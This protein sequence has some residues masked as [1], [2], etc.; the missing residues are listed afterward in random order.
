MLLAESTSQFLPPLA[1]GTLLGALVAALLAVLAGRWLLGP[2]NEVARRWSLWLVRGAIL[3]LVVLVLFNPVHVEELPGPVQRPELFY[4]LDTSSSM[5]MGSPRSRW[6]E[7]LALLR[8]AEQL[9]PK[10]PADVKAFRF[11]QRLAAVDPA[12]Q[13]GLSKLL[14]DNKLKITPASLLPADK[15]GGSKL[16]T[17][18]DADTRLLAALRQISSRFGRVPP[19]GIV[20]FSDGR[21]HDEAGLEQIAAEFARLKV[22]LHVAPVGDMSKGGDVAVSAVV[23]PPRARKFTEVDVQVFVRSFGYD[24]KRS[25]VQLLELLADGTTGRK[26][27]P[28]LPITL[29]SGFQSVSLSFRTD[30]NTRKLRVAIPPLADEVSAANNQIDAE[31][32]IER[33]KIRVLF[34][35]G[36]SQPLTQ[37]RVGDRYQIR[38]AFSDLKSALTED[39]DIECVVLIVQPGVGLA[40]VAE[41]ASVDGVRGFPTTVAELSAF[42]AII[43]SNVAAEQFTEKQLDWIEQWIGQRGGG[44]CMLGGESSFSSGGW[45]ESKLA[46]LLPVE[47]APGGYDWIGGE[48]V[49]L[50]AAMPASPHAL[51]G[52]VADDEQNR[53]IVAGFPQVLGVNRWLAAR[54]NL[55]SVLA[56][57]SV[58][59][60]P[61]APPPEPLTLQSLGNILQ[62]AFQPK[63]RQPQASGG[64][65]PPEV[66][67]P[68]LPPGEVPAVVAGRYGRGRTMAIA[69]PLTT[70]AA[71][72][73][74]Q[75]WGTSDNRYYAKFCRNLVNWLTESSSIGRRR[76]VAATDKRFYRPGETIAIQAA[77]YDESAA[78][79][80]N[81]RVVAMVEPHS[82][83][84]ET[85]PAA[86]PLKWPSG[87]ARESGETGP[88]V[89]WGEEFELTLGTSGDS[90]L[91][92]IQLSL[93][94]VLASGTSSQS[95]RVELTAYEDRTQVDST[96]LDI[97]I[98]HDPF[99]QQNPF[100]NHELLTRLANA[101]GGKVIRSPAEL[102]AILRNVPLDV[103]PPVIRRSPLWSTWW[104]WGLILGL[105]SLEWCWRRT[106]GLA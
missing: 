51:W 29:Q 84:G 54:P 79:T 93:A 8:G 3:A 65:Q 78:P 16:L 10:S 95:L 24:G 88:L 34:V 21:A 12:A 41:Y 83:P 49:K 31:M 14:A 82:A 57:T 20:V 30:L 56:T 53:Q 80:K 11:G 36:S 43:L 66:I 37:V 26:L 99:E 104:M 62:G 103:G 32:Q 94:E 64:R 68:P 96:S 81:Y 97:Q 18:T 85:E 58:S 39:E 23:A 50:A 1:A 102:A 86:S 59:S 22:P 4:L 91:H 67:Q 9:V 42:D 46:P 2:A 72:E 105:L 27:C 5:Q 101:S 77:T 45:R 25:E 73:L 48:P 70:P 92:Q 13:L 17:P 74:V 44:L 52:I 40:R 60:S 71:D 69:I 61:S 7:S 15:A 35:E 28:P 47:L 100:P 90:P 106:L 75:K 6:E 89:A 87:L 63:P 98:L 33:T 55:T 19:Q 38:G 76:L